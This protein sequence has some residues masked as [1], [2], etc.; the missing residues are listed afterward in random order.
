MDDK[1]VKVKLFFFWTYDKM[2]MGSGIP[3]QTDACHSFRISLA[4]R[5]VSRE[6]RSLKELDTRSS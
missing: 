3:A 4:Y 2:R 1:A 6:R 5:E